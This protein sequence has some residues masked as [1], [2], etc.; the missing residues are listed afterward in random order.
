MVAVSDGDGR[1][2]VRLVALFDRFL[3]KWQ[4]LL[5]GISTQ[6]YLLA[7][8]CADNEVRIHKNIAR[9]AKLP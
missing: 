4:V 3:E 7:H 1:G 6:S 8:K 2:L 9:I 5:E